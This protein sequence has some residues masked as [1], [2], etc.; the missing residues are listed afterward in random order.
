MQVHAN[1]M[2]G[3]VTVWVNLHPYLLQMLG[4]ADNMV[5]HFKKD[6]EYKDKLILLHKTFNLCNRPESV[7]GK[8]YEET[9]NLLRLAMHN[10]TTYFGKPGSWDY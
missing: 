9:L 1:L 8:E 3:E 2:V 6:I 7:Q 5:A 4:A 10:Y